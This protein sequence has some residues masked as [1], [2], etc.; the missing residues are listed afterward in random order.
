MW[1]WSH[2]ERRSQP[3]EPKKPVHTPSETYNNG[4][5]SRAKTCQFVFPF[6]MSRPNMTNKLKNPIWNLDWKKFFLKIGWKINGRDRLFYVPWLVGL[7]VWFSLPVRE[8][9]GSNPGRATVSSRFFFFRKITWLF[10]IFKN[11][12][13]DISL[14]IYKIKINRDDLFFK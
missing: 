1:L 6:R 4:R 10:F 11:N 5:P 13:C 8:V 7:G 14:N 2:T 3:E 9:P 12:T